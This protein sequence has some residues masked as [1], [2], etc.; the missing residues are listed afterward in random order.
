MCKSA[1]LGPEEGGVVEA[2]QHDLSSFRERLKVAL[3]IL[4]FIIAALACFGFGMGWAVLMTSD[5]RPTTAQAMTAL[6]GCVGFGAAA[7]FTLSRLFVRRRIAEAKRK[8]AEAAADLLPP[9]PPPVTT[10]TEYLNLGLLCSAFALV[11][12][13]FLVFEPKKQREIVSVVE[14]LFFVPTALFSFVQLN[15]RGRE[16]TTRAG[17]VAITVLGKFGVVV[18]WLVKAGFWVALV[19]G[20]IWGA[21]ALYEAASIKALLA[22]LVVLALLIYFRPRQ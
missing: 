15:E 14:L 10:A 6:L 21:V 12:A 17:A 8:E 20:C 9:G 19:G 13:Y 2:E 11:A 16:A 5:R 7:A 22:A 1:L 3:L 4:A 18:W